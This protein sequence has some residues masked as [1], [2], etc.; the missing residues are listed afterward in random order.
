MPK[1]DKMTEPHNVV[2]MKDA[3]V[4]TMGSIRPQCRLDGTKFKQQVLLDEG[5]T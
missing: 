3:E 1:E 4:Q 2:E 5:E